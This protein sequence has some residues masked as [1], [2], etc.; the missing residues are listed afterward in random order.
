M[1][2]V[3]GGFSKQLS[4]TPTFGGKSDLLGF[5]FSTVNLPFLLGTVGS[6]DK[7]KNNYDIWSLNRIDK[8][9]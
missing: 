8:P 7:W 1:L 2:I 3:P 9:I 4:M 5:G 6:Q